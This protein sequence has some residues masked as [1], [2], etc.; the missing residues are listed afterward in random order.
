MTET[1]KAKR[2]DN[3]LLKV[4]SNIGTIQKLAN[5]KQPAMILM[6][7]NKRAEFYENATT[8]KFAYTHSDGED[9]EITLDRHF[10]VTLQ[11]AG[12][13]LDI[14][15][16]HE[17]YPFPLPHSPIVTAKMIKLVIEK[18]VNDYRKWTAEEFKAK[19]DMWWK[20][21]LGIAAVIIA[22]GIIKLLLPSNPQ[23]AAVATEVVNTT[24]RNVTIMP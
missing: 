9:M 21:L 8:G 19:G 12:K 13:D 11:Y 1:S 15:F 6:R 14:Y 24:I 23:A 3:M 10:I 5:F 22:Y 18:T 16:C 4:K 7:N 17:D 2:I 20:I